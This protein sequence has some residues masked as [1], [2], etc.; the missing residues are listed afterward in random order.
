MALCFPSRDRMKKM[1]LLLIFYQ[2]NISGSYGP[3]AND[4]QC[5]GNYNYNIPSGWSFKKFLSLKSS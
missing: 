1:N 4:Y 3:F 5:E 2:R